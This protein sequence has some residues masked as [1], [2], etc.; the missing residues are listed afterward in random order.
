MTIKYQRR[1]RATS[2][3]SSP[4]IMRFVPRK[5][6]K[7]RLVL[8]RAIRQPRKGQAKSA[9]NFGFK[10]SFMERAPASGQLQTAILTGGH[11]Y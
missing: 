10:T 9:V 7:R 5:N 2:G 1:A 3:R 8:Y 11:V 6:V 4:I